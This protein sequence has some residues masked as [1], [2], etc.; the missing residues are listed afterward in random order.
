MKVGNATAL[1]K[2]SI[3]LKKRRFS[4][5]CAKNER[6]IPDSALTM[7]RE[8]AESMFALSGHYIDGVSGHACPFDHLCRHAGWRHRSFRRPAEG[9]DSAGKAAVE[10]A[11]R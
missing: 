7:L 5:F 1:S 11:D 4:S 2:G 9:A 3:P 6:Q 8:H 10:P